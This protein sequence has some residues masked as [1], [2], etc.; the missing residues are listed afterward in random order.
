MEVI[1]LLLFG[2][3]MASIVSLLRGGHP[4]GADQ[5][6]LFTLVGVAVIATALFPIARNM[7]D[8][9]G[10]AVMIMHMILSAVVLVCAPLGALIFRDRRAKAPLWAWW[11]I[12][13]VS[14]AFADVVLIFR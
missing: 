8:M 9:R 13:I 2:I 6:F 7:P 5:V 1:L 3:S 4:S 10:L 11:A 12:P 14:I